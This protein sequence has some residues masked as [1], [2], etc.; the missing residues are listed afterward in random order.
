MLHVMTKET[1][2]FHRNT[3]KKS[4]KRWKF[5]RVNMERESCPEKNTKVSEEL[6]ENLYGLL[7]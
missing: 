5:L 3:T 7:R 1:L 6:L 4:L 2:P